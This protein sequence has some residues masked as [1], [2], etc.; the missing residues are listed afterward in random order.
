MANERINEKMTMQDALYAMSGGNPGALTV[1]MGLLTQGKEIDPDSFS[2]GFG[3][4][5]MLDSLGIYES[6]IWL[7]FK[8]VCGENLAKMIAVL[9]ANQLGGLANVT[10]ETLNHAI[11]NRGE[12]IDL[13]VVVAEVTSRLSNFQL[14]PVAA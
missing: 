12:G 13:D 10:T 5:L 9:R 14:G 1:L 2:G 8:D 4:I 11:D 7:L 6:R 3:S